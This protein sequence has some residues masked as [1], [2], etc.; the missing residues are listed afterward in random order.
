MQASVFRCTRKEAVAGDPRASDSPGQSRSYLYLPRQM[1]RKVT[2][3]LEDRT[4]EETLAWGEGWQSD[5]SERTP[6]GDPPRRA[7][8]GNC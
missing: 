7:A 6:L 4:G 8:Q 1:T 5:M 2:R 3:H